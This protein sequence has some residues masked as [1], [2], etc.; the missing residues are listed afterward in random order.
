[1]KNFTTQEIRDLYNRF[2]REEISFTRMVEIMNEMVSERM[3]ET[4]EPR[5][6]DGD[7]VVNVCGAIII[8]KNKVEDSIYDHAYL[9]ESVWGVIFSNIPSIISIERHA[10]EDEKRKMLG[11]LAKKGK[12]WN[13]EKKCIEDIPVRKFKAGDKV[14]IKDGVSSKT[15]HN[16]GPGF[17]SGMDNLIGKTMTVSGYTHESGYIICNKYSWNFHEDW[18]EP[19]EE[20]KKGRPCNFFGMT[21]RNVQSSEYM[22]D[23]MGARKRLFSA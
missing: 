16:V 21:A 19:Y 5:Y 13:E 15:S 2:F 3:D 7:F 8:F 1:M 4:N 20:L 12:R 22:N 18:L 17:M 6:N 10:T 11:A 23:Q 14:R 9:S